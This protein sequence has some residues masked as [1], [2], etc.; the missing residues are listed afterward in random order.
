MLNKIKSVIGR[1]LSALRLYFQ[2]GAAQRSLDRA[3]DLVPRALPIVEQLAKLTPTRADDE[4]VAAAKAFGLEARA[5]DYLALPMERRGLALL[6]IAT[7]ALAILAPGA[8]TS[9]LNTAVQLAY[10]SW[11]AE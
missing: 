2:S 9:I 10:T 3:V 1:S 11:R 6:A 4:L 8:P 7:D 5:A